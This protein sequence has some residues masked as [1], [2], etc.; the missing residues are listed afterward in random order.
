MRK[1]PE[2]SAPKPPTKVDPE[3]EPGVESLFGSSDEGEADAGQ[4]RNES[5]GSALGPVF[6]HVIHLFS[7]FFHYHVMSLMYS[8]YLETPIF[9]VMI[10]IWNHI[11]T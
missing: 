2:K 1:S 4:S 8:N 7:L 10:M 3:A 6:L 9:H 11:Y 5:Q